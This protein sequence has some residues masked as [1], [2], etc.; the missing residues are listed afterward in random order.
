MD[1]IVVA[2][3][4]AGLRVGENERLVEG[5]LADVSEQQHDTEGD[6]GPAAAA[7]AKHHLARTIRTATGGVKACGKRVVGGRLAHPGHP[8]G[9]H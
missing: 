4:V 9:G 3:R 5:Q 8:I 6:Q 2:M 1:G 7:T